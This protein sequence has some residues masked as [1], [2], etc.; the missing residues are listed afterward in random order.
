MFGLI[1]L[2]WMKNGERLAL[3]RSGPSRL[4]NSGSLSIAML[5]SFLLFDLLRHPHFIL[6]S[7]TLVYL[8]ATAAEM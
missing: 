2:E 7:K 8:S 6:S 4:F 5:F 3:V 1:G